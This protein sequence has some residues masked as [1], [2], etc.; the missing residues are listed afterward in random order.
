ML[1]AGIALATPTVAPAQR[2]VHPVVT[3]ELQ[4][5]RQ[6]LATPQMTKALAYVDDSDRETIQEWLSLCNAH[7]PSGDEIQRSRLIYKLFRIYGLENVHIDDEFN[8]VGIRRGT[9]GGPAVVLNAHHDNVALS[10]KGQPVEAFVADGRVWCPAAGDDLMGVVQILTI[11]RAM[12]AA[13]I[14][15]KGDVWFATF[16]GEEPRSTYASRGIEHFVRANYPLNLD[17]K[18]GDIIVQL[19]GGGG[20][21]VTVGSTPLRH[22][23]MLRVY[24]PFEKNRWERHAVDAL[25]R[26]LTRV[27]DEVRDARSTTVSLHETGAGQMS[28]DILYLNM[29]MIGAS[30]IINGTGDEAWVR[31]DLRSPTEARLLKAHEDIRRVARE[32]T[33]KIG[34]GLDFVYEISSKN[35][36]AAGIAGWDDVNNG[37]ARMA[38]AASHALYNTRP[39]IDPARGCGDCVQAYVAGMPA[40]SLRGNVVD[41]GENGKFE[42]RRETPLR[43]A[44]R[45]RTAT[46]DVTE[47]VDINRAWSG[48]KH[49]LL[50]AV[51]YAGLAK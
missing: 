15:T 13:D 32:V 7:G 10:P 43:S 40:M 51:A 49:G 45:R 5:A 23:T 14:R 19:H 17:W 30:E 36:T 47:S 4:A 26:I 9:G 38:V 39:V 11:V 20:E 35:G 28:D 42:L 6:V 48:V 31:F 34:E 29:S 27:S 18:R 12:N 16:T 44:V 33:G 41:A 8:V 37:A 3:A 24:S 25:G 1:A 22:R 46:H 21:G 2:E 50:F